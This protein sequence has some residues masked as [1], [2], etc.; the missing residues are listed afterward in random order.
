[1]SILSTYASGRIAESI[2][3][4]PKTEIVFDNQMVL[5][6]TRSANPSFSEQ[7]SRTVSG[8]VTDQ[9][10]S[11]IPGA[12][13]VIKGTT[14]GVITNPDGSFSLNN[15]SSGATLV[16]SFV[17]MKMQEIEVGGK[18]KINAVLV[19]ETIGIEEVVAIGY[20][21]MKKSDLTGS[22]VRADIESFRDQPNLS[23]AESLQGSVAG[24]NVGQVTQAG[25]NSSLT[26]RGR[27]SLSG[28]QAPLIV[29]DGVVYRGSLIDINT[30]DILS[31]DVLKD[32]SAKAIYGSQSANGVMIIT[33]KD[34]KKNSKPVFNLSSF[35]SFEMPA[36]TL[37]PL[38]R[39]GYIEKVNGYSWTDAYLAPDY[40]QPNPNFNPVKTFPYQSIVDGYNNGTNTDW[41]DLTTQN[42]YISN[43]N[44]SM[45][46]NLNK[47]SYF[48][49]F[50]Y[51]DQAGYVKN[52][53]FSKINL[54]ANF[55]VDLTDWFKIGMQTFLS[56]ADYSG[57]ALNYE[58]AF[59]QPPLVDPYKADGS[60]NLYPLGF[61]INPLS[62]LDIDDKDNRLNI[63]GNFYAQIQFP[64][65]KGLS[66][67]ING[68]VNSRSQKTSQF[69]PHGNSLQGAASKYNSSTSDKSIDN[70]LLYKRT[71]SEKHG[72][73]VTLLYG[74]EGREG[75]DTMAESGGFLNQSLG[76][77]SLEIGKPELQKTSSGAWEETSLYQMARL[78]YRFDDKYLVTATIRRDGFSGFGSEQ[79]FGTFPSGAIAWVASK[80]KFVAEALPWLDNL[81]IRAAYGSS[82]NRTVGRYATLAK[83]S[84]GYSYVFGSASAYGQSISS[85]ANDELGWEKT[86]G[87]NTGVDFSV[88]NNRLNGSVD[89]YDSKTEDI[90]F[91][92]N[93]P[94]ITGFST[95]ASNIGQI[96]NTGFEFTLSSVN[97]KK[98]NFSWETAIVFSKNSNEIVSI[99]GRD[100]NG[101]GKEDDLIANS[102]FIGEPVETVYSYKETGKLY[103]LGDVIPKGYFPGNVILEDLNGDGLITSGYDRSILGHKE[104]AYRFSVYNEFRYINWT[105][106]AFI[107]SIQGGKNGYLES[108]PERSTNINNINVNNISKQWDYWTPLKPNAIHTGIKY[109]DPVGIPRYASRSFVRLQDVNLAYNLPKSLLQ[110]YH[111][112][113]IKIYVSG[114]NLYTWTNWLGIDPETGQGLSNI[115]AYPVMKSY[116]I[117]LNLTF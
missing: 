15:V 95:I 55:D 13:V 110:R 86:T 90:L 46:G 47:T 79:K 97:I 44:V 82:G 20:G 17:G 101:D 113:D 39:D 66:Y 98:S 14:T 84:G 3:N 41:I 63:F 103:Q 36:K 48:I 34:G 30:N 107:N 31:V 99:L 12:S 49:S 89:Y 23:I 60:L 59:W 67:R 96:A 92:I 42:A 45:A 9:T 61:Q 11:P 94:Q 50:G 114:K 72:V 64:F 62:G 77:N 52:D 27:N 100:D 24:L 19:E 29:L 56:T 16:F 5:S 25:E 109:D 37:T 74:Y 68:S 115:G 88:I 112:N 81:K 54:R 58:A 73:D 111:L 33:T 104:P 43:V 83:V 105:F 32:E 35:Y 69:N 40:T 70:L 117:G 21:T 18:S 53:N 7:V 51:V 71:F 75:E 8:K 76:Y 57:Y 93:I 116:S 10:G 38:D 6:E 102:L 106:S 108:N 28:S 87:L 80:E 65:L 26:I 85:M 78:N 2:K 91:N 1:M 4:Q 22:V